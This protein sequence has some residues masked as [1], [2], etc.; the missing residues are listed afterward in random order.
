MLIGGVYYGTI[1]CIEL[2]SDNSV[3]IIK[4]ED[5]ANVAGKKLLMSKLQFCIIETA[6]D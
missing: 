1:C 4:Y 3:L 6:Y 2:D 5:G